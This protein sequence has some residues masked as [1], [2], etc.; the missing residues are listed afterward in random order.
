M[1]I[2]ITAN[3]M[4]PA[5]R[6]EGEKHNHSAYDEKIISERVRLLR[7]S[8][9]LGIGLTLVG[10]ED[11][12]LIHLPGHVPGL[13]RIAVLRHSIN[14][15]KWALRCSAGVL[16]GCGEGILPSDPHPGPLLEVRFHRIRYDVAEDA[17]KLLLAT[18]EM[19][20]ILPLPECSPKAQVQIDGLRGIRFPGMEDLGQPITPEGT[21]DHMNMVRHDA[22]G[23][24][25]IALA[26]EME[27]GIEDQVGDTRTGQ[28]ASPLASVQVGIDLLAEKPLETLLLGNGERAGAF[29]NGFAFSKPSFEDGPGQRISK[30]KG[31]KVG[32]ALG[33]PVGQM[34]AVT[35]GD[36][37]EAR[38]RYAC[39]YKV[40]GLR[41]RVQE[42]GKAML[43]GCISSNRGQGV[44]DI[45]GKDAGDTAAKMAALHPSSRTPARTATDCGA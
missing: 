23:E 22:P 12:A 37:A 44:V 40:F 34:T 21:E 18:D 7:R 30:M 36:F 4:T 2:G 43:L 32:R 19:I 15:R 26:V 31:D 5:A 41:H 29:Q 45:A 11:P 3:T 14:S 42:N 28:Q 24:Q 9:T 20:V 35:N 13:Q 33:L 1:M 17:L 6:I 8:K 39:Y 27:Q 25:A 38:R 10:R 16:A